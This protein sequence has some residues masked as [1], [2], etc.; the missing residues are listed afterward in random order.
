[1]DKVYAVFKEENYES[2]YLMGLHKTKEGA[3]EAIKVWEKK[4]IEKQ[5][6]IHGN[7][8]WKDSFYIEEI[9]VK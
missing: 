1:M 3:E 8:R 5:M 4:E 7:I 9:E 6:R 2:D